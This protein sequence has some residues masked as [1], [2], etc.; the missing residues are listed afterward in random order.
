MD[1]RD[2]RNAGDTYY[3]AR[4]LRAPKTQ[5]KALAN[6]VAEVRMMVEAAEE[7]GHLTTAELCLQLALHEFD[8]LA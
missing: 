8:A 2:P 4:P 3:R 5:K 1:A 7:A 6:L